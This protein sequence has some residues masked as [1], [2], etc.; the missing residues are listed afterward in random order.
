LGNNIASRG[1]EAHN[2]RSALRTREVPEHA[3]EARIQVRAPDRAARRLRHLAPD[4]HPDTRLK[5]ADQSMITDVSRLRPHLCTIITSTAPTQIVGEDAEP[6]LRRL[7]RDIR[8]KQRRYSMTSSAIASSVG[9][10]VRPSR[11]LYSP[12]RNRRLS[13]SRSAVV[14]PSSRRPSSRSTCA[15]QLRIACADG[16]NSL[17]SSSGLRPARTSSIICRRNSGVGAFLPLW[18]STKAGATSVLA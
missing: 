11:L 14:R 9:G 5:S 7:T 15:T 3:Q 13:S 17:A 1:R 6:R 12:A 16:S 18:T 4:E 10:T 8:A 2:D